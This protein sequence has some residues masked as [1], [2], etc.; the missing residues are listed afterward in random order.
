ML[1]GL[2]FSS[3]MIN[4]HKYYYLLGLYLE[5]EGFNVF[6]KAD[7]GRVGLHVLVN[8]KRI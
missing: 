2:P 3:S 6:F 5:I 7:S 4:N 1:A 8:A